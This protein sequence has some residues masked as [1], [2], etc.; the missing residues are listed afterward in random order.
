MKYFFLFLLL[1]TISSCSIF[2]DGG[3]KASLDEMIGQMIMV[4]FRGYEVNEESLI[5]QHIKKYHIGGVI[6]FDYDVELGIPERNIKNPSQ[7][8]HLTKKLQS[9]SDSTL[10]IAVD[11]EGG[12]VVRL[13]ERHGFPPTY[14][15]EYLGIK[16]DPDFTYQAALD[17]GLTLQ[18]VNI[19]LNLAPVIDVNINPA[20]PAIGSLE[21]SFSEDPEKVGVHAKAFVQGLRSANVI[22]CLKHYP[23][24][25]SAF[26]DSHYGLTEIT[27]TWSEVELYPYTFLI[28]QNL[29]DMIMTGHLFHA[30]FDQ[31]HPATLSYYTITSMLRN[32][33]GYDGV[34]ISD[35]MNMQAIT[36]FYGLEEAVYLALQ[37]GID[38]ILYA[39]NM[40]YH[41]EIGEV[42]HNLIRSYVEDGLID[43]SRIES[44]FTRIINLKNRLTPR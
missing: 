42:I 6:L 17:I 31:E 30:D 28:E 41:P 22:S 19:N 20:N 44:S 25:G 29:V 18:S 16:N 33:L 1:I 7:V 39:N 23:G 10:L 11:Q 40:V 24:H 13:K 9:A 8:A 36:D 12:R 37:S 2:E 26:N 35:D 32:D 21:R 14:S 43:R 38:I 4:G 27:E 15:A 34:I 5:I 3:K